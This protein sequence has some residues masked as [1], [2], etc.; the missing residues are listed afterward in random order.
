MI[1]PLTV[2]V[3]DVAFLEERDALFHL[4]HLA[5]QQR[6]ALDFQVEDLGAGLVAW[7]DKN[8]SIVV[9]GVSQFAL[10]WMIFSAAQALA[11]Q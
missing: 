4:H 11:Q 3:A 8:Q 7:C 10:V 1:V 5:V 6:G 9:V 2:L